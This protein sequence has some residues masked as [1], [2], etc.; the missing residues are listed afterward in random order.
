M[1]NFELE[2]YAITPIIIIKYTQ[3]EKFILKI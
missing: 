1:F 3:T 2:L